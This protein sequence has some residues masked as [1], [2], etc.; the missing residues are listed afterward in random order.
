MAL[1]DITKVRPDGT[2][3]PI[4]EQ[5]I[6]V[7]GLGTRKRK[8]G[9]RYDPDTGDYV[10]QHYEVGYNLIGQPYVVWQNDVL[11]K[12]GTWYKIA[13]QDVMLFDQ[14]T[15][16]ETVGATQL[17]DKV[18]TQVSN[19][20]KGAGG[21]AGGYTVHPSVN[22]RGKPSPANGGVY[23]PNQTPTVVLTG[24]LANLGEASAAQFPSANEQD[25]FGE[26]VR[27]SRLLYYPSTILETLQD[28]LKITQYNYKA[29]YRD[30]IFPKD[31]NGNTQMPSP[32]KILTEGLQRTTAKKEQ[33]GKPVILPIPEGISD[34][35]SA[36]WGPEKMNNMSAA[37][38]AAMMKDVA[39]TGGA[40]AVS[41]AVEAFTGA[42]AMPLATMI[43]IL[44]DAASNSNGTQA[45]KNALQAQI[46]A[47]IASMASQKAGFDISPE[48]ILSRGH[49]MIPNQNLELL[50]NNVVLRQFNFGFKLSPRS[51]EEALSCRRIIRFFK[52]GMAARVASQ[53]V[54]A[55]D[56]QIAAS[57]GSS[58]L[59]LGT[60]NVFQLEYIHGPT[61][62]HIEGLNRFKMCA[63]TNMA[64]DYSSGGMYQSFEDGQ[65]AHM[66]MTLSFQELEPVYHSD[67]SRKSIANTDTT[68]V[69]VMD[70]EIGY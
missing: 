1:Q 25:L 62:E 3:D 29:P 40:L 30:A 34:T 8:Y 47:Q 66:T 48:T 64:M 65:P 58:S 44:N 2:S 59:F 22:T 23:N 9:T 16:K 37:V 28:H 14:A 52:Q 19:A 68:G 32:G 38:M 11:Y 7:P 4:Y 24:P 69:Q 46:Q 42:N 57:S 6:N 70:D 45:Q 41:G 33:V 20:H 12:N 5:D 10:V 17:T 50:F 35:N 26:S 54:S 63:L 61:G 13:T 55:D 27:A 31:A 15:K 36:S 56:S 51:K 18:K 39:F 60:P 43:S 49:G 53:G 67:Y 21:N